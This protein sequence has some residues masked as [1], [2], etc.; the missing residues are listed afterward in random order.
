MRVASGCLMPERGRRVQAKTDADSPA[1]SPRCLSRETHPTHSHSG[2]KSPFP[3][4]QTPSHPGFPLCGTISE[5][6]RLFHT[7]YIRDPR[8]TTR[9]GQKPCGVACARQSQ[10]GVSVGPPSLQTH[11]PS[12]FLPLEEVPS[13]S[14]AH[15]GHSGVGIQQGPL[16]QCFQPQ[17]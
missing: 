3:G 10:H 2:S 13:P 11:R 1:R 16:S 6:L 17:S 5:S 4:V 9:R 7:I 14:H 8:Q 15:S 12:A